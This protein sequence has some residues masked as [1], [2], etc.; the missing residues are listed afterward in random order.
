VAVAA[1]QHGI[2]RVGLYSVAL[3]IGLA[4]LKALLAMASGSLALAADAIDSLTD[5]IGSVAVWVG[6]RL[7]R[8]R[9]RSF[10][11][12]LYKL[13]NVASVVVSIFIFFA[14]YELI[15]AALRPA[16]TAPQISPR[17]IAATFA[18]V[19]APVLFG[20]YAARIGRASGSPSLIAEA[21]HRRIDAVTSSLVLVAL[22]ASHLG[23]ALDRWAAGVVA[24]FVAWTGWELLR[25]SMRVLLDASLDSET[26]ETI[27]SALLDDPAVSQIHEL[28]GRN[29]GRYRFVEAEVTVR[30]T[31]LEKAHAISQRL[32]DSIRS[33]VERIDRVLIHCEP[34]DKPTIRYALPL[35]EDQNTVSQHFGEAPFFAIVDVDSQS[36][37]EVRRTL[38]PNPFLEEEKAKGLKVAELLLRE[39]VDVLLLRESLRGKGPEYAFRDAGTEMRTVA[40][41]SLDSALREGAHLQAQAESTSRPTD[42]EPKSILLFPIGYVANEWKESERPETLRASTSRI[43]VHPE[44]AEGLEGIEQWET[45]TVIFHFHL[46]EGYSLLQHPRGDTS[47]PLRGVFTICSPRR[48]NHI[49]VTFVKLLHRDGNVLHVTGL[50][51]LDGTP[52]LDI[53]PFFAP[54]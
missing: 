24:A 12:G 23:L 38:I 52:V 29:S 18:G 32:S 1:E 2:E 46:S 33:K 8:R 34:E 7:S 15:R 6:L 9:S 54:Q 30:T 36:E 35:A 39:K 20:Q 42:T 4:T 53:K 14:A 31:D 51:A 13:E 17:I 25:D 45:L 49:G 41:D 50:D 48:P 10:P 3:N 22:V 37:R 11:Y 19:V 28:T 44:Y 40:A 21:Q 43:I 26:L 5:T 27:R 47:R 16:E